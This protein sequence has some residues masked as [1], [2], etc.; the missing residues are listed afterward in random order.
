MSTP[1]KKSD[2]DAL[3]K[4]GMMA[5]LIDA[6]HD[7]KD[8]G[9]YGRLTFTMV[10]RHFMDDKDLAKLL[11]Q[12]KDENEA[13]AAALVQQVRQAGYNP[14]GRA[15]I[16]EWQSKQDFPILPGDDPDAGNVYQDLD[17]PAGVYDDIEHY[18]D[19]KAEAEG[20]VDS[21]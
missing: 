16:R 20:M 17:F 10:A 11:A 4:N 2:L 13:E 8:I 14:P 18:H 19:E 1:A 7:G 5:H 6:L 15:K 21:K 12:D 3:K 9:H